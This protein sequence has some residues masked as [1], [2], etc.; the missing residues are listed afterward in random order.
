MKKDPTLIRNINGVFSTKIQIFLFQIFMS[1]LRFLGMFFWNNVLLYIFGY[2]AIFALLLF[3]AMDNRN[4]I[5]KKT[6]KVY[7]WKNIKKL[8]N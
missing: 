5:E 8:K 3:S 7:N 2:E 1:D 4:I 6:R